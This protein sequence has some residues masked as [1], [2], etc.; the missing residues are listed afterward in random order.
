MGYVND[1]FSVLTLLV[2]MESREHSVTE[3]VLGE[4]TVEGGV[5]YLAGIL[6]HL[7]L[8]AN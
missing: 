8:K 6:F 2:E 4:H 3:L 5:E 1:L 7:I